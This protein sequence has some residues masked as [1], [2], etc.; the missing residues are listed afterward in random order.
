M[1]WQLEQLK[2]SPLVRLYDV[3]TK[4]NQQ[5]K[6]ETQNLL[7]FCYEHWIMNIIFYRNIPVSEIYFWNLQIN[8]EII[9]FQSKYYLFWYLK[10][11]CFVS[12]CFMIPS[13]RN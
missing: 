13:R 1:K 8:I 4:E 10:I 9:E 5:T 11:D 3:K 7:N 2:F 12:G 6:N